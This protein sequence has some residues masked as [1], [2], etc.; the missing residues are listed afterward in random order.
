M[1]LPELEER[2]SELRP[3][4][5]GSERLAD[6]LYGQILEKIVSGSISPGEKLPSEN[7]LCRVFEVSRPT[8]REALLRLHADGL[9]STRQGSGT[10]VQKRPSDQLIQLS[11]S[12]D[13]AGM[14]RCMEVRLALEGQAARLAATRRTSVQLDTLTHALESMRTSFERGEAPT[15]ADYEFHAAVA[16]ASGNILFVD[17]L[18]SIQPTIHHSMTVALGLTQVGTADRA[19]RVLEEHAAIRDAIGRS[20]AES[21]ELMMRFHLNRARQRMTDSQQDI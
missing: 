20:D 1:N 8:V 4:R 16:A 10:V 7:E 12:S 17:V 21:S 14:L 9:V 5:R 3:A 19:R 11:R 18:N 13:V 6:Q 2:V 15:A